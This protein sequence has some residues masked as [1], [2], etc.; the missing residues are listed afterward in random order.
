MSATNEEQCQDSAPR[1]KGSVKDMVAAFSNPETLSNADNKVKRRSSI[2][3]GAKPV[4]ELAAQIPNKNV[5]PTP[6]GVVVVDGTAEARRAV[7]P[8]V[9]PEAAVSS[10][11]DADVKAN[12]VSSEG[13]SFET[14][15]PFQSPFNATASAESV[16]L[17]TVALNEV[18]YIVSSSGTI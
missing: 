7:S 18:L 6:K 11:E 3:S 4:K 16:S 13:S 12:F 14:S 9:L 8:P 10:S 1:R 2:R 17:F 5:V 15:I